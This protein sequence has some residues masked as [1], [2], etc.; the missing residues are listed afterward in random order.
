LFF[1]QQK[2]SIKTESVNSQILMYLTCRFEESKS[3]EKAVVAL[4]ESTSGEPKT[5]TESH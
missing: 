2:Q 5:P 1:S 4:E 3:A